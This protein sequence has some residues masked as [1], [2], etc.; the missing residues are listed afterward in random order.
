MSTMFA[1]IRAE[2]ISDRLLNINCL[3]DFI[4]ESFF[5]SSK[6][7]LYRFERPIYT[8]ACLKIDQVTSNSCQFSFSF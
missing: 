8:K 7:K 6:H 1:F 3:S 4:I 5:S 2:N